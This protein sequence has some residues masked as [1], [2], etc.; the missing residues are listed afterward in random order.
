MFCRYECDYGLEDHCCRNLSLRLAI[1]V[2]ACKGAGQE[3]ARKSHFMLSR[4]QESVREWHSNVTPYLED[5]NFCKNLQL[6]P[7]GTWDELLLL[8]II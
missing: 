4:V 5:M 8:F 7:N 2:K 6:I 1:K 3:W